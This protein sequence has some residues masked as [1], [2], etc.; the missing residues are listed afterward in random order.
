MALIKCP[1]CEKEISDQTLRCPNCGAKTQKQRRRSKILITVMISIIILTSAY[2]A[3]NYIFIQVE[4]A[5][6][7]AIAESK[8]NTITFNDD[9]F[10][11]QIIE[12]FIDINK[13]MR[14]SSSDFTLIPNTTL[15]SLAKTHLKNIVDIESG[16]SSHIFSGENV[17]TNPGGY[18]YFVETGVCG[19]GNLTLRVVTSS[20]YSFQGIGTCLWMGESELESV[21]NPYTGISGYYAGVSSCEFNGYTYVCFNLS[22]IDPL[23]WS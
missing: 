18:C 13:K 20:I 11:N 5:K 19:I 10:N 17:T 2:F 4:A 6:Q 15:S 9:T 21:C 8:K 7:E 1:D 12:D 3:V 22:S 16:S 23:Y 14:G